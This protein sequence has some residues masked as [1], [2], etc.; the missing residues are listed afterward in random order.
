MGNNSFAHALT[1]AYIIY[2]H[3]IGEIPNLSKKYPSPFRDDGDI[4]S[5]SFFVSNS[6]GSL[7][8]TD[9]G[10]I[11]LREDVKKRKRDHVSF[12]MQA[13][14]IAESEAKDFIQ[15]LLSAHDNT[16][17]AYNALISSV[18]GDNLVT[19]LG[20]IC[21][22]TNGKKNT[23]VI[24]RGYWRSYERNYW[25]NCDFSLIQQSRI[26]PLDA[27]YFDSDKDEF[28]ASE[29]LSPAFVYDLSEGLDHEAWKI[30]RPM[31]TKGKWYSE[32][33][34]G[35]VEG[36]HIL[37]NYRVDNIIITSSRK[38][39]IVTQTNIENV[40][41]INPVNEN[42]WSDIY[43]RA[44]EINSRANKIFVWLDADN[45][46]ICNTFAVCKATGWKPIIL[47]L[48]YKAL[49]MKDQFDIALRRGGGY[50]KQIYDRHR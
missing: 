28:I 41:C 2:T 45:T 47:G 8:W 5:L 6:D 33:L 17:V 50:L 12:V 16:P 14:G 13:E 30:Y 27:Y 18:Q 20:N 48:E 7:L 25:K 44:Y 42:A 40:W 32:N 29:I 46:G 34:N 37:P 11:Q 35:V 9:F 49:G 21:D 19:N 36:W 31:E 1:N 39:S 15:S 4:P 38:D 24:A 3:Y 10:N 26:Y 22:K 23:K 43:A